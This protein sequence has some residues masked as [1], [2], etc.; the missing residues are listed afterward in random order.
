M[1][2]ETLDDASTLKSL[3][4]QQTHGVLKDYVQCQVCLNVRAKAQPFLTIP[5]EVKNMFSVEHSLQAFIKEEVLS[6]SNAVVCS[7]EACQGNKQPVK[8]G[9]I[10]DQLPQILTFQLNRFDMDWSTMSRI[11]VNQPLLFPHTLNMKPFLD[12]DRQAAI[13]VQ[14][15]TQAQEAVGCEYELFSML[16]HTGHA[17]GGHYFAYTR[18][19]YEAQ[20]L[21]QQT[22]E[23][24][25]IEDG[26]EEQLSS[27]V[28]DVSIAHK[29]KLD[30]KEAAKQAA[31]CWYEF[32]DA[33]V[34]PLSTETMSELFD[35]IG[36]M[37]NEK[38]IRKLQLERLVKGNTTTTSAS[39]NDT[40]ISQAAPPPPPISSTTNAP[41]APPMAPPMAPP[42][43]PPIAPPMAPP[44]AP[45]IAP[46]VAPPMA[47]PVAPPMA[48]PVAPPM[49]PPGPPPPSI[50]SP[51]KPLNFKRTD[52]NT[53][54][55]KEDMIHDS[56]FL[57]DFLEA[58]D[59]NNP[60]ASS[61]A[62]GKNSKSSSAPPSSSFLHL[63]N[64]TLKKLVAAVP[65]NSPF[66][67]AYMLV[68]RRKEPTQ[69]IKSEKSEQASVDSSTLSASS[70]T[71]NILPLPNESTWRQMLPIS[72]QQ[73]I[74]SENEAF[75][76]YKEEASRED[77]LLS[78]TV[79]HR[80]FSPFNLSVS[81]QISL[82]ALH[83]LILSG[84][85]NKP[86]AHAVE[87]AHQVFSTYTIHNTKLRDFDVISRRAGNYF[88][89]A[90]EETITEF[91]SNNI[92]NNNG[93][94]TNLK[95]I[96]LQEARA[97]GSFPPVSK[98][99]LSLYLF[100]PLEEEEVD[101]NKKIS[102]ATPLM[103]TVKDLKQMIFDQCISNAPQYK[104]RNLTLSDLSLVICPDQSL[105][106]SIQLLSQETTRLSIVLGE[107]NQSIY[108]QI[109]E[110]NINSLKANEEIK[111]VTLFKNKAHRLTVYFNPLDFS[112]Q[113]AEKLV[114]PSCL[115]PQKEEASPISA[116]NTGASAT[117]TN[118]SSNSI[119]STSSASSAPSSSA[120]LSDYSIDASLPSTNIGT[121]PACFTST[122]ILSSEEIATLMSTL[123]S[124]TI[125]D[126][127]PLSFLKERILS[128]LQSIHPHLNLTLDSFRLR[129]GFQ[130]LE[131]KDLSK[132]ISSFHHLMTA[133]FLFVEKGRPLSKGDYFVRVFLHRPEVLEQLFSE[134][135]EEKVK[136]FIK[137]DEF[138]E[139]ESS[140]EDQQFEYLGD[141]ILN[142]TN[143][144]PQICQTLHEQLKEK[145][146]PP[147]ELIRL[148]DRLDT[149]LTNVYS[150]EKTLRQ[151]CPGLEDT[152]PLVIQRLAAPEQITKDHIL[153]N[154]RFWK[155][156]TLQLF[157][158]KEIPLLKQ[159]TIGE[160][161]DWMIQLFTKE[162]VNTSGGAENTNSNSNSAPAPAPA[163]SADTNTP[164][165]PTATSSTVELARGD[166]EIVGCGSHILKDLGLV[167]TLPW[168][169]AR[170]TNE[171]LTIIVH[172]LK[173]RHGD[174]VL[175]RLK[176]SKQLGSE[177][178]EAGH[179]VRAALHNLQYSAAQIKS[180]AL[181][182]LRGGGPELHIFSQEELER[183]EAEELQ[184]ALKLIEEQ[185]AQAKAI[186][187]TVNKLKK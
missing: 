183:R 113:E 9:V 49:A 170:L 92:N 13:D 74:D 29:L 50:S 157:P 78:I 72:A 186:E 138:G 62:D 18:D 133:P 20:A 27:S 146:C 80:D 6:G 119:D 116:V 162:Y 176:N 65:A 110:N 91:L 160:L 32:D 30:F 4:Y 47:P 159:T 174:T 39:T 149:T 70:L 101:M 8:K 161:K 52:K 3:F 166:I 187:E 26:F 165:A 93:S 28:A 68:Y 142:E 59:L 122:Q 108:V 118:S 184:L 67:Q 61:Q 64:D 82:T 41:T 17:N 19:L 24:K 43:A 42:V 182:S 143:T 179:G 60:S 155:P 94:S 57:Q 54:E 150:H 117:S 131:F 173:L 123:H 96:Y 112:D 145:G 132:K 102:L 21:T 34:L 69:P 137:L 178:L 81:K 86:P 141:V 10:F 31:T 148:R 158:P 135:D 128:V 45:P 44:I 99:E 76:A 79:H 77:A 5:L 95:V 167:P 124:V 106:S 100:D 85:L 16:L 56:E 185:E 88:T 63:P 87:N 172:P 129:R 11:K 140:L 163:T 35:P 139:P 104:E 115:F 109:G 103:A 151:N 89:Y 181:Q 175:F 25:P 105:E 12:K 73:F 37:E 152:Y 84:L 125:D 144:F 136:S 33:A 58:S 46:P 22:A 154:V 66:C 169:D 2:K 23:L 126:R 90:S 120:H 153:V 134:S 177:L 1:E 75:A 40:V 107:I 164:G 14:S 156:S 71:N 130:G 36:A 48:P 114:D 53:N 111:L 168:N 127:E 38:K 55:K 15:Q 147:P 97:D 7:S 83:Q 171:K 51:A 98:L 121:L 180:A